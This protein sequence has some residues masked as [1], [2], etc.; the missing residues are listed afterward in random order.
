MQSSQADQCGPDELRFRSQVDDEMWRMSLA[1]QLRTVVIVFDSGLGS[2][3]SP[4][5]ASED[6]S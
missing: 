4:Q 3:A 5:S 6:R 2:V 1:I